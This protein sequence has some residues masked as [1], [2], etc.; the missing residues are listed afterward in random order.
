MANYGFEIS[1]GNLKYSDPAG[2]TVTAS[3]LEVLVPAYKKGAYSKGDLCSYG[4]AVYQA[5]QNITSENWTASH[6]Q[7]TNLAAAIAAK[8]DKT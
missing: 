1:A 5:K 7:A 3:G 6:W 2:G 4:G 8:A